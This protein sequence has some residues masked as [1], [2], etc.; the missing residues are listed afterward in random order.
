MLNLSMW[1]Y[2]AECGSMQLVRIGL[3][4]AHI[5]PTHR[6]TLAVFGRMLMLVD[7]PG[8]PGITRILLPNVAE[9][10]AQDLVRVPPG[11]IEYI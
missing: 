1:L 11:T 5:L 8:I 9:Q 10:N 3:F 4:F 2:E 7:L 6:L